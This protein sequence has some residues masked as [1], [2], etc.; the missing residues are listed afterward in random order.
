MHPFSTG[1]EEGTALLAGQL[2]AAYVGP[3][4]TIKAWQTSNGKL[5][6]VIS[7]AASGGVLLNNAQ[8][9]QDLTGAI[10]IMIVI[11]VI[12]IVVDAIFSKTDLVVRRRR[13]LLT[14]AQST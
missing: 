5:I 3:N 14:E 2:D 7:G 11:L 4:P 8:D 1:T 9:N 13:G 12:G 10:S 6:R